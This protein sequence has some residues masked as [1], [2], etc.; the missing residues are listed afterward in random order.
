MVTS[1][2]PAGTAGKS[3]L[4]PCSKRVAARAA[5]VNDAAVSDAVK[6][7][8]LDDPVQ[9]LADAASAAPRWSSHPTT[10]APSPENAHRAEISSRSPPEGVEVTEVVSGETAEEIGA[11]EAA[12]G[13]V[14]APMAARRGPQGTAVAVVTDAAA[15][16]M[17]SPGDAPGT[18]TERTGPAPLKQSSRLHLVQ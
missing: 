11:V 14:G 13:A 10:T 15:A 8:S 5:G 2:A 1:W 3:S 17:T 7:T 18:P 4:S 6:E 16:P 12:S 9:E